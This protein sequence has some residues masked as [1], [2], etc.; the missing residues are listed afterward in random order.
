MAD[1]MTRPKRYFSKTEVRAA[2]TFYDIE[3][4]YTRLFSVV[5]ADPTAAD[6]INRLE[7]LDPL[8][9]RVHRALDKTRSISPHNYLG[10]PITTVAFQFYKRTSPW[11]LIVIFNG[12]L[13]AD[14]IPSGQEI[15]IPDLEGFLEHYRA[16]VRRSQRTIVF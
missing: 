13:H 4:V 6:P 2:S 3:S 16:Q 12:Y 14:E 8:D 7:W 9:D 11:W 15:E 5:E 10:E 1:L